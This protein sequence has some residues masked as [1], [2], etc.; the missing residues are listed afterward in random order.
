MKPKLKRLAV[1][2]I[3]GGMITAL[4]QIVTMLP[5]TTHL[6]DSFQQAVSLLLLPGVPLS[7]L[8]NRGKIHDTNLAVI[9]AAAWIFYTLCI[10]GMLSLRARFKG[11]SVA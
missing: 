5:G 6:M 4:P 10:Y 11:R 1:S 7:L 2:L 9:L 8:L 3:V